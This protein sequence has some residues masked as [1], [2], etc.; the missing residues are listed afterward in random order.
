MIINEVIN[1]DA[2][3]PKKRTVKGIDI[4]GF[5]S[6]YSLPISFIMNELRAIHKIEVKQMFSITL[7]P[8]LVVSTLHLLGIGLFGSL[9]LGSIP[10][11][12][13]PFHQPTH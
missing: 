6:S 3:L 13:N 11:H 5:V 4:Q 2:M 1:V 12:L 10:T 7:P 8:L 9:I